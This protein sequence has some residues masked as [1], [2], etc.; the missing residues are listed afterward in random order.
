LLSE[1]LRGGAGLLGFQLGKLL[2][3]GHSRPPYAHTRPPHPNPHPSLAAVW[4]YAVFNSLLYALIGNLGALLAG[5]GVLAWIMRKSEQPAW[6]K[7]LAKGLMY[8]ADLGCVVFLM[9]VLDYLLF[10]LSCD[11]LQVCV[12]KGGGCR[13][14]LGSTSQ[15]PFG[16]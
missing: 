5:F 6:H 2:A 13:T 15:A 10:P 4:G 7:G 16:H 12:S 14:E 3:H 8:V 9:S 1:G 11:W